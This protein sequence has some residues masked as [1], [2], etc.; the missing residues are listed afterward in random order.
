M[1]H[2]VVWRARPRALLLPSSLKLVL[3]RG[4]GRGGDSLVWKQLRSTAAWSS[5]SCCIDFCSRQSQLSAQ[6]VF[7]KAPSFESLQI[8][9]T[10]FQKVVLWL[11][12]GRR[13]KRRCVNEIDRFRFIATW[14]IHYKDTNL[15]LRTYKFP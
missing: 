5:N 8:W 7:E 2:I 6:L 4:G 15:S 1:R 13:T 12:N 9:N 14:K 3:P 11:Q 10:T